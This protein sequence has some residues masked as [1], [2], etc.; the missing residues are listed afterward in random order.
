M[1]VESNEGGAEIGWQNGRRV[2]PC[3]NYVIIP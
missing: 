3:Q 1:G 2:A